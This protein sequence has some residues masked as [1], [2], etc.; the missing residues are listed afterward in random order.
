MLNSNISVNGDAQ[1]FETPRE[2]NYSVN[3]PG[4]QIL[5]VVWYFQNKQ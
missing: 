3:K 1:L 2:N 5:L 4:V